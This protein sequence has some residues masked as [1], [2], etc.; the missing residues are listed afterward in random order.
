MNEQIPTE[1]Y[2]R[3]TGYIRPI[4][5]WNPGKQQ[6]HKERSFFKVKND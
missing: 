4:K 1:T 5:S 2:S 6:E 3:V